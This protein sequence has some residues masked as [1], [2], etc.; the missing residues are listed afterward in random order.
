MPIDD[1]IDSSSF[2]Y[3]A[4]FFLQRHGRGKL[5]YNS[6]FCGYKGMESTLIPQFEERE[7][8]AFVR[9]LLGVKKVCHSFSQKYQN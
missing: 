1:T 4:V 8:E 2:L 5:E 6:R 9:R 3:G 7:E